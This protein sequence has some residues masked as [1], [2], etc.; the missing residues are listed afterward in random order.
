MRP[1]QWTSQIKNLDRP[2]GLRRFS[3]MEINAA[4]YVNVSIKCEV[5]ENFELDSPSASPSYKQEDEKYKNNEITESGES[6]IGKKRGS[7]RLSTDHDFNFKVSRIDQVK[8]ER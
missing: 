6:K 7:K 8:F 1:S 5:E 2:H 3:R 4:E